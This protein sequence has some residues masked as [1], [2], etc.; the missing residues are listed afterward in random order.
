MNKLELYLEKERKFE[1][2]KDI[3][4]DPLINY[5]SNSI[6]IPSQVEITEK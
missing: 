4:Q 1:W 3:W 2:K 6:T 5:F